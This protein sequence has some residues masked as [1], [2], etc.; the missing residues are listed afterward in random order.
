MKDHLF[1]NHDLHTITKRIMQRNRSGAPTF[2]DLDALRLEEMAQPADLLLELADQLRV[3]VLVH[4]G[5]AYDLLSSK[6]G[7]QL[8]VIHHSRQGIH[9]MLCAIYSNYMYIGIDCVV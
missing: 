5:L 9:E 2:L 8:D 7:I 4:D 1:S 3:A 6:S